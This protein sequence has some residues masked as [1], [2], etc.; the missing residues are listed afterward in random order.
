MRKRSTAL[1]RFML[2]CLFYLVRASASLFFARASTSTGA[3]A[4]I[5]TGL[6]I[7][8]TKPPKSTGLLNAWV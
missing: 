6:L 4:G 8:D 3:S 1:G 5:D 7:T 2:V